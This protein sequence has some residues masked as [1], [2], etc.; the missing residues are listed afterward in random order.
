MTGNLLILN[1]SILYSLIVIA[2]CNQNHNNERPNKVY[3]DQKI[4]LN[5]LEGFYTGF[6]KDIYDSIYFLS[7]NLSLHPDGTFSG[8]LNSKESFTKVYPIVDLDSSEIWI[9][10]IGFGKITNNNKGKISFIGESAEG[11]KWE[12]E[13]R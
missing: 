9:K 8:I 3:L 10:E 1:T 7:F 5:E 11:I 13:K 12:F 4:M 6:S 2:G